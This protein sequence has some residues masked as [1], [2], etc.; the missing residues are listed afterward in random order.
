ME[1]DGQGCD[2]LLLNEGEFV[3]KLKKENNRVPETD[4]WYLDNGASS[5]MTGQVSKFKELNENVTGR[6]RFGDGSTVEIRGKGTVSFRSKTGEEIILE[7]VY[8]IPH[9]CNNIISIGQLSERGNKVVI[10]DE[11]LWVYDVKNRLLMKVLRSAN[12]L[13]KVCIESGNSTCLLSKEEE[14]SKL[15]HSRLGHVNYQAMTLMSKQAMAYG[16]PEIVPPKEVC[17]GCLMSK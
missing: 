10:K 16:L 14:T 7:E 17:A 1:H 15:W 5:H 9:L 13:Y 12:R 3:P 11:H 6:V 2:T 8:Y 4:W